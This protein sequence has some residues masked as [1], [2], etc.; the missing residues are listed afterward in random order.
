MQTP[1][2]SKSRIQDIPIGARP[3]KR[4]TGIVGFNL[5][6]DGGFPEGSLVMVY[7]SPLSGVD[8]AAQ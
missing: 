6:L 5:L 2:D 1:G 4:S 8:L 3:K 7:G